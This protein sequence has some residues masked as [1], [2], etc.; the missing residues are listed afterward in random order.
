MK[1]KT[2]VGKTPEPYQQSAGIPGETFKQSETPEEQLYTVIYKGNRSR[3]ITVNGE[4]LL[5]RGGSINPVHPEKY[6]SGVP[7]NIVEN[8]EFKSQ[9]KDFS[10]KKQGGN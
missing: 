5:F 1:G 7:G 4:R 2:K 6:R 10:I 3:E 8:P 9:A